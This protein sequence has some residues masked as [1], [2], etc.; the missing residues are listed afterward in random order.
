MVTSRERHVSGDSSGSVPCGR[1]LQCP[2]LTRLPTF[3]SFIRHSGPQMDIAVK[4][5][6]AAFEEH[7]VQVFFFYSLG[8][9]K[10]LLRA[11]N[12][13]SLLSFQIFTNGALRYIQGTVGH[14][15]KKHEDQWACLQGFYI[16][17]SGDRLVH[18]KAV[19]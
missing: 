11:R 10:Y 13:F 7:P 4:E 18:K 17:S 3:P 5:L 6:Q 16:L 8:E 1:A 14:Y 2:C 9:Y 15:K 12:V 19:K